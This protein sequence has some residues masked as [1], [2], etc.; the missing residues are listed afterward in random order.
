MN[1]EKDK[2]EKENLERELSHL[3]EVTLQLE[4][5]LNAIEP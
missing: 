5:E 3:M 4:D 1:K 2:M